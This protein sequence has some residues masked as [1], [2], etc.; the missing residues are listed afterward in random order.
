MAGRVTGATWEGTDLASMA[1]LGSEPGAVL[2][3][4]GSTAAFPSR[5]DTKGGSF[6]L[7]LVTLFIFNSLPS[8]PAMSPP[9]KRVLVLSQQQPARP[10]CEPS[11]AGPSP[12][13][14]RPGT[15]RHTLLS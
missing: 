12:P 8:C 3:S 10:C 13:G 5:G 4:P 15:S 6:L 1:G 9:E 14:H 7:P 2:G 11:V